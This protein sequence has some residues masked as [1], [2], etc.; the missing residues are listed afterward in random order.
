MILALIQNAAADVAAQ[1]PPPSD[2]LPEQV[3][4]QMTPDVAVGHVEAG[5]LSSLLEIKLTT[6]IFLF[7]LLALVLLYLMSRNRLTTEFMMRIFILTILI[8]GS[9]LVVSSA[10]TTEQISPV[11]GF[12]GTIAGYI[13]GRG[14]RPDLHPPPKPI[15]DDV[16][17]VQ[18]DETH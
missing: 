9:L 18:P 12:F 2:D 11:I 3:P 10:F 4:N 16:N 6:V 13:L 8:F 5:S 17:E 1:V 15:P 14:D 7:G